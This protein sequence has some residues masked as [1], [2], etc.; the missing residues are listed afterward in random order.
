MS[1][2]YEEEQEKL[3]RL[4]EEVASEEE[5]YDEEEELVFQENHVETRSTDSESEQECSDSS[6]D[7]VPLAKLARIPT[8]IGKDGTTRWHKHC[9]NKTV[10]TRRENIIVRLP[11]VRNCGKNAKIPDEC[12]SLFF[13]TEMLNIIGENTSHY[14]SGLAKN[15]AR[16]RRG[17][18]AL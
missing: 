14:I 2:Y 12:W 10:R 16:E 15:Y 8:F 5:P 13:T 18:P 9:P 7:D 4:W 1:N 17:T 3:C 6:D 11:G